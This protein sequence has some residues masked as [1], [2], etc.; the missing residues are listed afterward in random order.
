MV[1]KKLDKYYWFGG[2][3]AVTSLV[4]IL[5]LIFII[6]PSF[7]S[8][9]KVDK[10]LKENK[11]ELSIA[12]QKLAKLKEFKVK[13]DELREQSRVVYRA[14]PTKKEVGDLFIQLNGLATSIGG[15]GNGTGNSVSEGAGTSA[16]A[17][18]EG[19]S[20][21]GSNISVTFP[22]YATLKRLLS[23]SENTLRYLHLNSFQINSQN[24]FTVSLSYTAYYRSENSGQPEEAK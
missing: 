18:T 1:D 3:I 5:A 22:D 15:T 23:E 24:S 19:I 11:E 20:T 8:I 4:V 10:D 16:A 14:I 6:V 17:G 12:E 2:V 7:K 9:G 21:L 13:E